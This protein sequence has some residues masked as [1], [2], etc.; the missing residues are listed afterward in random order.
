MNNETTYV[1]NTL[2][3]NGFSIV[4]CGNAAFAEKESVSIIVW[5]E[6]D[7][8]NEPTF[9]YC[10]FDNDNNIGKVDNL[11]FDLSYHCPLAITS[12]ALKI[13]MLLWKRSWVYNPASFLY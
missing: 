13:S 11:S 3:E 8:S 9:G 12:R 10:V 5:N 4:I 2:K 1:I 7:N 6:D